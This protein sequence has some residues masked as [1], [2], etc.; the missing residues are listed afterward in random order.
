[1]LGVIVSVTGLVLDFPNWNQGRQAM[2]YANVIHAVA[3]IL[4]VSAAF[5]HIYL[6]TIGME[7][8]YRSMHDGYVDEEWAREHHLLWYEEVT[9]GQRPGEVVGV[10]AHPAQGDD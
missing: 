4:F 7:G 3:A 10:G 8:A 6:G 5:G 1:V 9:H 2:Q